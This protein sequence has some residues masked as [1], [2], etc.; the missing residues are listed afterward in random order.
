MN[1]IKREPVVASLIRG[2]GAVSV[3][4]AQARG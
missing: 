3:V 4:E 2:K 1:V